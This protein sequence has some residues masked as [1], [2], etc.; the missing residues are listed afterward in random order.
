MAYNNS[1]RDPDVARTQTH[2]SILVQ[3]FIDIYIHINIYIRV[4]EHLNYNL[5]I[6]VS[7]SDRD[8]EQ[9]VLI[10]KLLPREDKQI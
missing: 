4:S 2:L 6:N 10:K 7:S 8:E 9:T 5:P 1:I 3:N